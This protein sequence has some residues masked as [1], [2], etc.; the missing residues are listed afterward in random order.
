MASGKPGSKRRH[1]VVLLITATHVETR[2][3]LDLFSEKLGLAFERY[4]TSRRTYFDLGI[5]NNQA[6]I[7]LAES[8]MGADKAYLAA[9]QG[10]EDLKP[11]AVVMVGI[12]FGI[13]RE[14][15]SV[16]DI[17]VSMQIRD[18]EPQKVRP[19][20]LGKLEIILRGERV[21]ASES[22]VDK[23]SG[24]THDWQGSSV[25]FGLILSGAKLI[26]HR[27]FKDELA[28]FEP[29]A[30]G[31][32][33]E[34]MGLYR[35]V[36]HSSKKVEW[37][38]VKAICDWADGFKDKNKQQYQLQAARNAAEYLVHVL[39]KTWFPAE[40][41]RP[42][43]TPPEE[44]RRVRNRH[45]DWGGAPDVAIFFGRSQEM[46]DL[47]LWIT[48]QRC[49][50]VA[51]VGLSGGGKT[52]LSVRLGRGSSESHYAP[53]VDFKEAAGEV[54]GD[55]KLGEGGIG[56][57]DLSLRLARGIQHDFE[58]V[59]WR[60]LL[61]APKPTV[62]LEELIR[63][64]SNQRETD[65][66]DTADGQISRLLSHF[67]AHRCLVILDNVE[68]VL[69]TDGTCQNG[70]E[71]YER[72]F[73]AVGAVAHQSC[74]LLTSRI[75]PGEVR[76]THGEARPVRLLYLHGLTLSDAKAIFGRVGSF[77]G[78]DDDWSD[79]VDFYDGNPLALE[80]AARHI[81]T[82]FHG[83]ISEFL[84]T[85]KQ[86]FED[87]TTLLDWYFDRF[88]AAHKEV[89][90]WLAI[91]REPVSLTDLREDIVSPLNREELP[92]TLD[93]IQRLLP[94][95]T[96][97]SRFALQP[98]LI[99]YMTERMIKQS[100]YEICDGSLE[101][102]NSHALIKALAQDFVRESQ[103]RVL[104]E[105]VLR[106]LE[107]KY[108]PGG[109]EHRLKQLLEQ[110]RGS[111]LT[112]PGYAAGNL[113]NLLVQ[114]R[115]SLRGADFSHLTIW[116]A[117]MRDTKLVDVNFAYA[118]FA[119]CTFTDIFGSVLSVAVSPNGAL[120]AAGTGTGEIRLWHMV[121]RTPL[122]VY[123]GH[124]DWVWALAFSPDGRILASGSSDQT[125]R[126][127]DV[128]SGICLKVL[129][130]HRHRIRSIAFRPD[131]RMLASA[132]EDRTIRLW[133]VG[134]NGQAGPAEPVHVLEGHTNSVRA[135]VFAP[136]GTTLVSGSDDK[137]VRIWDVTT[138]TEKR[139]SPLV[140]HESQIWSVALS[141]D[142]RTAASGSDDQTVRL[143]NIHTGECAHILHG[144][145]N[146]I[147]SLAFSPKGERLASASADRTVRIWKVDTGE[148]EYVLGGHTN[149]VNS[150][151]F[152]PQ[153]DTVVSG[154]HD[155]TIL[156]W[157]ASTGYRLA[158]LQG[159]S[160]SVRSLAFSPIG[161]LLA[162]ADRE[163]RLWNP[164]TG[165]HI[166]TLE[167]HET[168]TR[169]LA[170]DTTGDMLAGGSDDHTARVWDTRTG[171][172]RHTLRG[173]G[174]RV[175]AIAF[176]PNGSLLATGSDDHTVHVW[177][178]K[179][180]QRVTALTGHSNRIRAV[181]FN[182]SGNI[183]ASGSDDQ[184][185]RLWDP[186][187]GD[188]RHRLDGHGNRVW[189][190]AFSPDGQILA[191]GSEDWTVR[192]WAVNTGHCLCVLQGHANPV[193]SIAFRPDGRMLASASEDRTIRLWDVGESGQ[194]GPAEPLHV[195]E[196]HTNPIWAIAFSPDN[197]KLASGGHDNSLRLWDLE[198][199]GSLEWR[200]H[201]D[202]IW[203]VAFSPDGKTIAS[204]SDDG[205][206]KVW[207][208]ET[209][210]RTYTLQPERPYER[211]NITGATG[212]TEALK[213]T[214]RALGA[215]EQ[216]PSP[217]NK[218]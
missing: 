155:Q 128:L 97:A 59:I 35:A 85:G 37:I 168:W 127:W 53:L 68:S 195:L 55:V 125:V 50:L 56:K 174:N 194:A 106:L 38:L 108:S 133:D 32:E 69:N 153:G 158:T 109:R 166:K 89:L 160:S 157:Q 7:F 169:A 181:A 212:F 81:Q 216:E 206:C 165:E 191:S 183:L 12:A 57:T 149:W 16:G 75:T 94:L 218:H 49:R 209:G 119:K 205:T 147:C 201:T 112:L 156:L 26:N 148:P 83:S 98:V 66:P 6:R 171:K 144:H 123:S 8:G 110:L 143:W 45:V 76:L 116:Q 210:V 188:L 34:A 163:V 104:L 93:S 13:T 126:L 95:E 175:K 11:S 9:E 124:V 71:D 154:S 77:A 197:S 213:A 96:S 217:L 200:E 91:A 39:T 114:S 211:M 27:G 3:V 150:V 151:A 139:P 20:R 138:G 129:R 10:I 23:F 192:L 115:A 111:S 51:I 122:A 54:V 24:A 92:S 118:D 61:N 173:H 177:N 198:T 161:H 131:G 172:L 4:L 199:G 64:L 182:R 214:L 141:R 204:G 28:K 73:K 202:P 46:T 58:Y 40:S 60:R 17:L 67:Q 215:V 107:A 187:S 65:M 19:G 79:L 120:V 31:G 102:M 90:F 176:S 203:M 14:E 80:L 63:F 178:T 190:I 164:V 121:D 185:V 137:T 186:Q 208:V 88:S 29:E 72:L 84:R 44:N 87:I 184:T 117:Y 134:E 152:A 167:G 52:W 33:M 105:P 159:Y 135:V 140:G 207:N 193:W 2:A 99:E 189:S 196:G 145:K 5:L 86:M 74:L 48:K 1:R 18:Y 36:S 113:L 130:G 30:I 22:L 21:S 136:D 47:E 100:V 78:T 132:S 142:G 43:K 15:Q 103:V 146:W 180:G 25:H 70:Y 62:I 42:Q 101:L 162:T 179:S 170:F 41:V 82:V